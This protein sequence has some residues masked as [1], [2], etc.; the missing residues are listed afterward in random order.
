[1]PRS[2]LVGDEPILVHSPRAGGEPTSVT[3]SNTGAAT[4]WV[5]A[6]PDVTATSWTRLVPGAV[7]SWT[8]LPSPLY[9]VMGA[10]SDDAPAGQH[11]TLLIKPGE[12]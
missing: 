1:M 10:D 2:V 8:L 11:G 9:A 6:D 7:V 3:V 12:E 4:V 5:G